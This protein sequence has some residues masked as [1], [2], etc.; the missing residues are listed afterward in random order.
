MMIEKNKY[1]FF[2]NIFLLLCFIFAFRINV[3]YHLITRK[4]LEYE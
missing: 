3:I 1:P 2:N 4:I